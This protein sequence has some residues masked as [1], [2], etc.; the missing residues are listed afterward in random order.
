MTE[1]P[2]LGMLPLFDVHIPQK[3]QT[4]IEFFTH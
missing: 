1:Q 4:L 3:F 2:A